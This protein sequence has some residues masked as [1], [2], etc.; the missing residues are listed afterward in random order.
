MFPNAPSIEAYIL[1]LVPILNF[2]RW[3]KFRPKIKE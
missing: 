2:P 1:T 3:T